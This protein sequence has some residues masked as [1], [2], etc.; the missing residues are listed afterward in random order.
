MTALGYKQALY[1]LAISGKETFNE[2][3]GFCRERCYEGFL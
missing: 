1:S 2:S 3:D